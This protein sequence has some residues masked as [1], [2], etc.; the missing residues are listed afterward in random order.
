MKDSIQP[1]KLKVEDAS[2]SDERIPR[3]L[4]IMYDNTPFILKAGLEWKANQL[5]GGAGYSLI[6]EPITI[7]FENDIFVFKAI[8]RVLQNGAEYV[9]YGEARKINANSTMQK[10]LFH[11]AI[12]RAECRV[13]RM[14]T[15]CGYAS[16]DEVMTQG[17]GKK[18]AIQLEDGDKVATEEQLTTLKFLGWEHLH[19][20]EINAKSGE[21]EDLTKQQAADKIAELLDKKK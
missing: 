10:Q 15:A 12:T 19:S 2:M 4:I 11:L 18:E 3:N 5:F 8:L 20:K 14:A 17:N 9:N 6:T 13:I 21:F 1:K 7:D 16:Y